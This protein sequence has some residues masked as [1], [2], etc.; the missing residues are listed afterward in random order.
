MQPAIGQGALDD[1][2]GTHPPVP[3]PAAR[4]Q[5]HFLVR[6]PLAFLP[7]IGYPLVVGFA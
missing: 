2:V 4:S 5:M 3:L 6:F 7:P 1:A